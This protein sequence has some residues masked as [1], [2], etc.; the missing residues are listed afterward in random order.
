MKLSLRQSL[1]PVAARFGLTSSAALWNRFALNQYEQKSRRNPA[2]REWLERNKSWIADHW[3]HFR[4]T[5]AVGLAHLSSQLFEITETLRRRMGVLGDAE[6]L[7][8][9]A[10]DGMF[11]TLLGVRRGAGVNILPACVEKIRAAGYHA[12]QSDVEKMPVPDKSFDFVIC[13]ETL[14]HVLNPIRALNELVRVCRK[15]IF[16]TI[17]WLARTRLNVR[18]A[19]WP[20][21]ESHIF[22]FSRADFWK[23][24][25]FSEAAIA[26]E[27]RLDVF[28][29]PR[30][31]LLRLWL[32]L[33]MYPNMTPKLQY[34]ELTP[35]GGDGTG[36][37]RSPGAPEPPG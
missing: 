18:P 26:Y 6:V 7:D 34:Y 30:N 17:P 29:E 2:Y 5:D 24:V 32:A 15:K 9:G 8:A 22:E 20:Q 21:T 13:T 31:P 33:W 23:L 19:G 27:D 25:T 1:K 36:P 3:G 11:L 14:E 16:I 12:Y 10:S 28:P 37:S 4:E 35:N